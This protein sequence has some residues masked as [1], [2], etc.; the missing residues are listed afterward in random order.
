MRVSTVLQVTHHRTKRVNGMV[1]SA[2]LEIHWI[3]ITDVLLI[4]YEYLFKLLWSFTH[5]GHLS[6]FSFV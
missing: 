3:L 5:L 4:I 1:L 6:I 2:A